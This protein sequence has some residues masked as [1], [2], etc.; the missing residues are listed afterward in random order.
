MYRGFELDTPSVNAVKEVKARCFRNGYYDRERRRR[1]ERLMV[2][3]IEDDTPPII[4]PVQ[5]S[6]KGDLIEELPCFRPKIVEEMDKYLNEC[7]TPL[8]PSSETENFLYVIISILG[9]IFP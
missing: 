8:P 1:L 6:I 3:K 2:H 5:P 4:N 7:A 9:M